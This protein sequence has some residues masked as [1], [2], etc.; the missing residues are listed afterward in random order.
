MADMQE[1]EERKR[2]G[3]RLREIRQDKNLS[4]QDL[5]NIADIELSQI[6]RIE[7]AKI[8]PKLSTLLVIARALGVNAAEF[9]QDKP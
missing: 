4:M 7:T 6:Y 9:F 1:I 5:A 8:N 3:Q 2:I